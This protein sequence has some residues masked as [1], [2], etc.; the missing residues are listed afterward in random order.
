MIGNS[1][2][3]SFAS[4]SINKSYTS[5]TTSSIR[6]SGLSILL[7][8]KITGKSLSRAFFKT[9]L[10]WGKGPSLESTKRSTPSTKLRLLSTS[11]PKSAWPGVSTILIFISL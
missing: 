2:C 1:I 10:V 5:S 3:L 4:K 11:P 6:A 7:I 8:A 9:N